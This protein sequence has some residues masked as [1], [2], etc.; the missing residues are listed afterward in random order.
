MKKLLLMYLLM[1]S[2]L[3]LCAAQQAQDTRQQVVAQ[4]LQRDFLKAVLLDDYNDVKKLARAGANVNQVYE[5]SSKCILELAF[6]FKKYNAARA[7]IELDA[8]VSDSISLASIC[9][10]D[11][12]DL[13]NVWL[14]FKSM[15]N[16]TMRIGPILKRILSCYSDDEELTMIQDCLALGCNINLLWSDILDINCRLKPKALLF[17]LECGVD[18]NQRIKIGTSSYSALY[19]YRMSNCALASI[20]LLLD[21]GADINAPAYQYLGGNRIVN[22]SLLS[23]VINSQQ[24]TDLLLFLLDNGATL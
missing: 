11:A 21:Y 7:L 22:T 23:A 15:P 3:P 9:G 14:V 2:S 13:K 16:F 6:R 4:Q 24:D 20:K 12:T 8:E 10:C 19:V 5:Q 18:P 17:F 1:A